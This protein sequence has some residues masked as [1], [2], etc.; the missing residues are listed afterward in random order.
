M[1]SVNKKTILLSIM[2]FAF[3]LHAAPI[4]AEGLYSK[5]A[6]LHANTEEAEIGIYLQQQQPQQRA[7]GGD[8]IFIKE[9]DEE[10]VPIHDNFS[11]WI[12]AGIGYGLCVW[13]KTTP[14][15]ARK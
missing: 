13:K 10:K 11:F 3:L 2:L 1:K 7:G 8:G 4:S 5:K 12:F 15:K 9:A 14:S 6:D